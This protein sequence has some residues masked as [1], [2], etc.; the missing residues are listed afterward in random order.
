M[1]AIAKVIIGLILLIIAGFVM[2][3]YFP[4]VVLDILVGIFWL[5]V[6]NEFWG[7][8]SKKLV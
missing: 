7:W 6:L 3:K 5:A 2:E 8:V 1:K 4:K